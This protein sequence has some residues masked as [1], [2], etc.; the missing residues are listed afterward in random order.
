MRK[1]LISKALRRR[2]LEVTTLEDRSQPALLNLTAQLPA[3]V[4]LLDLPATASIVA[5]ERAAIGRTTVTTDT[6]LT[7]QLSLVTTQEEIRVSMPHEVIDIQIETFTPIATA[8]GS[9]ASTAS[10]GSGISSSS[11]GPVNISTGGIFSSTMTPA[12]SATTAAAR[13]AATSN[14]AVADPSVPASLVL[15]PPGATNVN[16]NAPQSTSGTAPVTA[17]PNVAFAPSDAGSL[18]NAGSIYVPV[19][20]VDGV[21]VAVAPA[22]RTVEMETLPPAA[23]PMTPPVELPAATTE[24]TPSQPISL[25]PVGE[26]PATMPVTSTAASAAEGTG[27]FENAWGW[28]GGVTAAL[29]IGGYWMLRRGQ[30]GRFLSRWAARKLPAG[31]ILSTDLDRL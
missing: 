9:A 12:T 11:A 20:G 19:G 31:T 28:I 3:I 26:A 29:A 7:P 6:P 8:G 15:L 5:Q 10:S 27:F 17:G 1:P 16:P 25:A 30:L 13:T 2:F 23:V 4:P 22:P 21:I 24:T 14:G 18:A